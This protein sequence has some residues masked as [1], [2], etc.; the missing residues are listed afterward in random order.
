M[1]F[2]GCSRLNQTSEMGR[3]AIWDRRKVLF[4]KVMTEF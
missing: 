4:I 2:M 3:D 1:R